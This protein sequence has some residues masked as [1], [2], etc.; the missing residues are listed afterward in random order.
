MSPRVLM[1]FLAMLSLA[2]FIGVSGAHAA[3]PSPSK[4]FAFLD[5]SDEDDDGLPGFLDPDDNDDGITD[6]DSGDAPPPTNSSGTGEQSG[7]AP[8]ASTGGSTGAQAPAAP[9]SHV[10]A[11][12]NTGTGTPHTSMAAIASVML[13]LTLSVVA[14]NSTE[15]K[16]RRQ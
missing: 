3:S 6:E 2:L 8:P 1:R 4:S 15:R 13:L 14:A 11:L 7:S 5:L 16:S 9:V 10:T 12:P